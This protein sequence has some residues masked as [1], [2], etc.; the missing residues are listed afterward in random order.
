ML[1]AVTKKYEDHSTDRYFRFVFYCD[2]CGMAWKSEH[3]PFSMRDASLENEGKKKAR[4]LMWKAEHDAAYER[5]NIEA[6]LNFNRCPQCGQRVCDDCFAEFEIVCLKYEAQSK[7]ISDE[8]DNMTA[9]LAMTPSGIE[10]NK[11]EL[12]D[13]HYLGSCDLEDMD[14]SPRTFYKEELHET[15]F[16]VS[17]C[18]AFAVYPCRLR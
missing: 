4:V 18:R 8:N 10:H 6:V 13:E 5:A 7:T 9:W 3:Y 12:V 2:E 1:P 14:E 16:S 17:A 11:E 15:N